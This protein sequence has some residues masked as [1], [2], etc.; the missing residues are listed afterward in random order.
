MRSQP[1]GR[2]IPYLMVSGFGGR[3]KPAGGSGAMP[4]IAKGTLLLSDLRF[5]YVG[6]KP[7]MSRSHP[8]IVRPGLVQAQFPVH[9][10]PHLTRVAIILPIVLPPAHRAQSQRT[11]RLQ[12]F[13]TATR[14][15]KTNRGFHI[16]IDGKIRRGMT[17]ARFKPQKRTAFLEPEHQS[18]RK[19]GVGAVPRRGRR[20]IEVVAPH[21]PSEERRN[22]HI[23]TSAQSIGQRTT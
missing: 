6:Q 21:A 14:T 12:C 19:P 8:A 20:S 2:G 16:Y 17:K 1:C 9:R 22:R 10:Q 11:G 3:V 7:R 5:S 18:G 13:V 15:T 4:G 23:H